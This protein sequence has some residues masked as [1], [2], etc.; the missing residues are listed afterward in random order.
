MTAIVFGEPDAGELF[1]H[2]E[3][4]QRI[5]YLHSTTTS[6]RGVETHHRGRPLDVDGAGFM[7]AG[8]YDLLDPAGQRIVTQPT[9]YVT[10]DQAAHPLD[11][12]RCRGVL[13]DTDGIPAAWR[14]PL[15]GWEATKVIK[16]RRAT[17]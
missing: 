16:L 11:Q 5:P 4:V 9:L 13:Y 14:N 10:Y 3:T 15:T 7:P 1:P 12:W 17:G 6:A 2:G 8:S